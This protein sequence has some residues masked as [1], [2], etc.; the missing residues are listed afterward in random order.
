LVVLIFYSFEAS[1]QTHSY[2]VKI[3]VF[4]IYKTITFTFTM[5]LCG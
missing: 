2:G 4:F 3:T 1:L 5:C